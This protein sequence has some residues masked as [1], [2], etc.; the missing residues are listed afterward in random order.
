MFYCVNG[1]YSEDPH[2]EIYVFDAQNIND[3]LA[4]YSS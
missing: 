3:F 4:Q 1:G 2:T